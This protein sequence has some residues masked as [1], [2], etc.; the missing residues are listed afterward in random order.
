MILFFTSAGSRRSSYMPYQRAKGKN[1]AVAPLLSSPTSLSLFFSHPRAQVARAED[2]VDPP[3][4]QQRLEAGREGRRPVRDVEVA[5]AEDEHH[6]ER[7]NGNREEKKRKAIEKKWEE[8]KKSSTGT[9]LSRPRP[10]SPLSFLNL[11]SRLL[12]I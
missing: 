3:G 12:F 11:L 1:K 5:D 10:P 6:G 2:V 8:E 4:D 7:E 9:F